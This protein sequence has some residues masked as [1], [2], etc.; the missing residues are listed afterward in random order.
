M[1]HRRVVSAMA[2]CL[3][4]FNL[5]LSSGETVDDSPTI[6]VDEFYSEQIGD[7]MS[8]TH[9]GI[10]A[11]ESLPSIAR[12]NLYD[13][14][15]LIAQGL[16]EDFSQSNQSTESIRQS[17]TWQFVS[18]IPNPFSNSL[19]CIC[20]LEVIA[21]DTSGQID[22]DWATFYNGGHSDMAFNLEPIITLE[23][24]HNIG[25]ASGI[26]VITGNVIDRDNTTTEPYVNPAIQWIIT[27][28]DSVD[29]MCRNWKIIPGENLSWTDG[30]PIWE[31]SSTLIHDVDNVENQSD[32]S[33]TFT[34]QIN[35]Q[36][37]Q[38]GSYQMVA[39]T[40]DYK[41]IES[42]GF[43]TEINI[44]NTPPIALISGPS[45]ISE[46]SDFIQFDGSA[47]SDIFWGRQDLT[48]LWILDGG[49]DGQIV[50]S[51][52]D[53]RTFNISAENSGNY[54]LTLT[55]IDNAGFSSSNITHFTIS[56]VAP[57]AR[58]QIDGVTLRDGDS[59]NLVNKPQWNLDCSESQDT[60]N[61]ADALQCIWYLNGEAIMTGEERVLKHSDIG[62]STDHYTLKLVVQ[63]DNGET[64]ELVITF[65]IQ[66]T[67]SDL[68]GEDSSKNTQILLFTVLLFVAVFGI[69]FTLQLIY[70]R[71]TSSSPIPKWKR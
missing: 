17:W 23:S 15:Q 1:N 4:L 63:D 11:D 37:F 60:D 34:M 65:G 50:T 21:T 41:G 35:T 47:S 2:I 67:D 9:T 51:G 7:Y 3:L 22:T 62:E 16:I 69:A 43:C 28:D 54:T 59:L 38:D 19:P 71:T 39:R 53:L 40:I 8:I 12:W 64:D 57:S 46:S 42:A 44:D 48:F 25:Q 26:F 18:A 27:T 49:P 32:F 6:V 61:D 29:E 70:R 68:Y 13:G 10:Y 14:T 24:N 66:G 31:E 36:N 30:D 5:P 55:V 58:I 33:G 45:N 20:Y 56:N 52:K